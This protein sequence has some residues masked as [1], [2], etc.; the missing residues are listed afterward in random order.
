M[1]KNLNPLKKL[2]DQ[3]NLF[4]ATE[5]LF[6]WSDMIK[7]IQKQQS[8]CF[9]RVAGRRPTNLLKKEILAQ[10]FSCEFCET[11]KNTF[12]TEHLWA[13]ASA[14]LGFPHEI[15]RGFDMGFEFFYMRL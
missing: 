7:K 1:L 11:S 2:L 13:T 14:C 8:L 15:R 9:N 10:V 3:K 6:D 12:F 5:K 4:P